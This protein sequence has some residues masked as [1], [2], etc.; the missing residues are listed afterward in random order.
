MGANIEE[1]R[2]VLSAVHTRTVVMGGGRGLLLGLAV[3]A[4]EL[5]PPGLAL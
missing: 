1:T 2:M 5:H 4:P 3:A